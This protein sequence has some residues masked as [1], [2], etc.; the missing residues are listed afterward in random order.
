MN[1]KVRQWFKDNSPLRGGTY[2]LKTL[3]E[4]KGDVCLRT[5][6]LNVSKKGV[7]SK[8]VFRDFLNKGL[9]VHGDLH[10]CGAG[11]YKVMF[12]KRGYYSFFLPC[13]CD[14]RW[15]KATQRVNMFCIELFTSEDVETIL[16]KYIPYFVY[17][18]ALGVSP[19]EYAQKFRDYPACELL[20]KN[21]FGKLALDKRILKL[22]KNKKKQLV[23]FLQENKYYIKNHDVNGND[24]FYAMNH[25]L[26]L[27]EVD[28]SRCIDEYERI[29][30]RS[31]F[32][33]T[34]EE[35]IEVY[36]YLNNP[37]QVQYIGLSDYID[38]LNMA[39]QL[40]FDMKAKSTIY[41]LN[42]K[43][44]H[45]SL[46]REIN[47]IENKKQNKTMKKI[48]KL[49]KPFQVAN[50]DLHIV[51]PHSSEDFVKWGQELHICVGTAG[52][53]EKMIKGNV[54]ILM[55]YVN[56]EPLECCELIKQQN[57]NKLKIAQLQGA[58]NQN[59]PRHR[60]ARKLVNQ[61]IRNYTNTQQIGLCF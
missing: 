33:K 37:K 5:F 12:E 23:H 53:F 54:L 29:F 36:K 56:D 47:R 4:F 25:N 16:K 3:E 41:P 43:N 32:K 51:I 59:S 49:L 57:S 61:F 24:V 42:A 9:Y 52:Y 50:K 58:H 45:N 11:G 7:K 44:A 34:R 27:E 28:Y 15:Y 30:N 21:G 38:Y 6:A 48:Y 19:I 18:K 39:K 14:D 17:S 8:E 60:D 22:N 31:D 10:W 13:E 1:R 20:Y 35:C 46:I 40:G 55:V 26:R 2:F